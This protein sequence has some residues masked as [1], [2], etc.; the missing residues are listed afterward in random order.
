MSCK[1]LSVEHREIWGRVLS[2]LKDRLWTWQITGH[3]GNRA[4]DAASATSP[5]F[6]HGPI[7]VSRGCCNLWI[8]FLL[9]STDKHTTHLRSIC[10]KISYTRL[11]GTKFTGPLLAH[12]KAE[13]YQEKPRMFPKCQEHWGLKAITPGSISET[14]LFPQTM[15]VFPKP[16]GPH[17][18]RSDLRVLVM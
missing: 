12:F 8:R 2:D 9:N 7:A 4:L 18:T 1:A 16:A 15:E 10:L 17:R 3:P 5:E 14:K 6:S 11:I 13:R